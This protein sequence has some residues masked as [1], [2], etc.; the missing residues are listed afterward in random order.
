MVQTTDSTLIIVFLLFVFFVF[1]VATIIFRNLRK[2][3]L[4]HE[5]K[6]ALLNRYE[7]NPIISPN[8]ERW[9]ESN[10]T[11]NPAVY[12][13]DHGVVHLLYRAIGDDGVSRFGYRYSHDGYDFTKGLPYPAFTFDLLDQRL[14]SSNQNYDFKLF[15]SGGSWGGV[16]DPRM[17]KIGDRIYVTFNTFDGW[18][19]IR[20]GVT[21]I[22][23]T[24]FL[25]GKLNWKKPMIISPKNQINKN[26]VLFPEKINNKFAILHSISPDIQIDYVD[27]LEDLGSGVITIHSKF[28]QKYRKDGWDNWWRG[29]GPPPIKTERGWLVFYHAVSKDEMH[30]YKL[31]ALLLDL[32]DPQKIIARSDQPLLTPDHWYENEWKTGVIYSCAAVLKNKTVYVY[33]GGGD[34]YT[35]VANAP[36]S[37]IFESFD[38][39]TKK[40]QKLRRKV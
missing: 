22:K 26:W 37:K 21:S 5:Q 9:W 18:N 11:F 10:G 3:Y 6:P 17:V 30:K 27:R 15:P 35:C 24:D 7:N 25:S 39:K 32:K 38:S 31:G 40:P 4:K 12:V 16:E 36:L 28:N 13:D 20:I 33:Y 29:V 2:N 8:E 23:E 1:I 14:Q 19:F 34:K